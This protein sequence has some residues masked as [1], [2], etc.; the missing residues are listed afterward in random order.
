MLARYGLDRSEVERWMHSYAGTSPPSCGMLH[1]SVPSAPLL[2]GTS[3]GLSQC[4]VGPGA[5]L[6]V[7]APPVGT[8]AIGI[9]TFADHV[10]DICENASD[11]ALR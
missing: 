5:G 6:Q 9:D 2:L 4:I 1:M 8:S 7:P 10:R 3:Q 11:F